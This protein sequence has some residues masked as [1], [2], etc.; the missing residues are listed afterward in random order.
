[1]YLWVQ[2][3]WQTHHIGT[4]AAFYAISILSVRFL[5]I[6]TILMPFK[7][8]VEVDF[9]VEFFIF[10]GDNNAV[11][12]QAEVGVADGSFLNDLLD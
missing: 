1:M 2:R 6:I 12:Q 4:S 7:F 11:H 5:L 3:I 10:L 8:G 9:D